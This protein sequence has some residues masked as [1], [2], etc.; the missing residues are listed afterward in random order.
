MSRHANSPDNGN[1]SV[2]LD[3]VPEPLRLNYFVGEITVSDSYAE[4]EA[5]VLW[6]TFSA[7]GLVKGKQWPGFF[8]T[9]LNVLT[10]AFERPE[11][12]ELLSEI[13]LPLLAT[14]QRWHNYRAHVVHDLLA[15]GW[16]EAGHV[17]SAIGKSP[18]RPMTELVECGEALGS[19]GWRLRGVWIV[20]PWWIGGELDSGATPGDM[21][22]WTRVIMGEIAD[23]PNEIRGTPGPSPEPPGGWQ[24]LIAAE[25]AKRE[26]ED[27]RLG[28]MVS[29]VEPDDE[30]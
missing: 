25:V 4:H 6:N 30:P 5:R 24:A 2:K 1:V 29:W 26:A 11:V 16:G 21:R 14:T 19:C 13:V 23:V 9:L 12:P 20:A 10:E 17:Q 15:I 22:S 7:A 8:G 3:D 18:P 28:A 27:A